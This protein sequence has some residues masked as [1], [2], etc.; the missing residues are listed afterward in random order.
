MASYVRQN[1]AKQCVNTT[2][3]LLFTKPWAM[4]SCWLEMS[5]NI[6]NDACLSVHL[7]IHLSVRLFISNYLPIFIYP[8]IHPSVCLSIHAPIFLSV[9]ISSNL[10]IFVIYLRLFIYLIGSYLSICIR[11]RLWVWVK[12]TLKISTEQNHREIPTLPQV[13]TII[14]FQRG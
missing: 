3:M 1:N 9:S 6:V 14:H 5:G 10:C 2:T 13:K 12:W 7:S 11:L 4:R 8:S